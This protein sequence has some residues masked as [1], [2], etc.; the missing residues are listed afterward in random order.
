MA[1]QRSV[2]KPE[3]PL[4]VIKENEVSLDCSQRQNA[5]L[6]K[7]IKKI[8]VAVIVFIAAYVAGKGYLQTRVNTPYDDHKVRNC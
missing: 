8:I 4:K 7:S 6:A 3:K 1:R 5:S 2:L